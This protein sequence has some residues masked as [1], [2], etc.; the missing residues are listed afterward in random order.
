MDKVIILSYTDKNYSEQ[1]KDKIEL[2]INPA[3]VKFEKGINYRKDMQLGGLGGASV[4][5]RYKEQSFSFETVLDAT[6]VLPQDEDV[7]NVQDLKVTA[8]LM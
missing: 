8:R 2:Q 3:E 6:G 5:D 4:F 7:E 1:Y